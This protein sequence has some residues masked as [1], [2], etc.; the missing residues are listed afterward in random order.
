MKSDM[1]ISVKCGFNDLVLILAIDRPPKRGRATDWVSLVPSYFF[2]SLSLLSI[3]GDQHVLL[4][5]L[6]SVNHAGLRPGEAVGK[7]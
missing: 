1:N 4:A 3:Y 5:P 7:L 6:E 2:F